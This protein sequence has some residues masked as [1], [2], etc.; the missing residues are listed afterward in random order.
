MSEY[1]RRSE[2]R[3]EILRDIILELHKGMSPREAKERF[4]REVG[5]V[6]S[7]EIAELEQSLINEGLSPDEIKRFCNVHALLFEDALRAAPGR[8]VSEAH[9]VHLFTLE[10]REIEKLTGRLKELARMGG[11][12]G[13]KWWRGE[14]RGL[15]ERLRG[16]ELHYTRKEQILFPH[17]ERAGFFGPSKVM[18]AKDD[19][20]RGL[21]KES[22]E[23][24]ERGEAPGDI[25]GNRLNPL[26][27]EVEGMI[28]KEESILFPTALEKLKVEDWVR[29]LRDSS[30]VGYAFIKEPGDVSH[31]VREL[32]R[33]VVEE[34]AVERGGRVA[35]PTGSFELRELVAVLNALPVDIT[36]IDR[37]DTVRYFSEGKGRIFVRTGSVIGRRVQNCHPPKSVAVVEK[38]LRSFKSGER[39]SADFWINL[40]GRLVFIRYFAVRDGGGGYLGTLEV[41]QDVTDI[42]K[43]E[44]EKRLLDWS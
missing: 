16:L 26:I 19:E 30:E 23:A 43:L 21:L 17:L 42:K 3:R 40:Q 38:I 44:G 1:M 33:S 10:N 6:T 24:L 14:L 4:V 37:D 25:I 22:I 29:V 18:W 41:T 11:E 7:S 15:L 28:F 9:P 34:P 35:L 12:L 5:S 31:M 20:I 27:E 8:D 32:E 39:D 36:F 2:K 13:D